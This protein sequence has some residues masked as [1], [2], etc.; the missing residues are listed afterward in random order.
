MYRLKVE[1]LESGNMGKINWHKVFA[2]ALASA[3]VAAAESIVTDVIA[4]KRRR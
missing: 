2:V 3:I 1:D 4:K